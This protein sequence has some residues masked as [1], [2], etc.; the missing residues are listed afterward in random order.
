MLNVLTSD[1]EMADCMI[2]N[3]CS[4]YQNFMYMKYAT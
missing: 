1:M 3:F 2:F 4:N